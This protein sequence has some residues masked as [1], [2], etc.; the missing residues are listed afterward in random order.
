MQNNAEGFIRFQYRQSCVSTINSIY[1]LGRVKASRL[2]SFLL[3]HPDQTI[4]HKDFTTLLQESKGRNIMNKL[5]I[6]TKIRLNVS[7]HLRDKINVFCYQAYRM[8]QDLPTKG[9]RTHGNAGTPS[10]LNPY[11]SLNINQDFYHAKRVEYK[12]QELLNNA[13]HEELKTFND[14][15]VNKEKMKKVNEK[16]KSKLSK[17]TFYKNLKKK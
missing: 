13:R 7:Q 8:F 17:Q 15:L 1:G 11:L 16:R 9:Q 3:N 14:E 5:F 2:N 12:R 4:F 6:E 10:H